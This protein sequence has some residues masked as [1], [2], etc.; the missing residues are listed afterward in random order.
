MNLFGICLGWLFALYFLH[1]SHNSVWNALLYEE[2]RK[3]HAN[4]QPK[5]IPNQVFMCTVFKLYNIISYPI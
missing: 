1:S 5:Q 4:N 3:Y 2:W